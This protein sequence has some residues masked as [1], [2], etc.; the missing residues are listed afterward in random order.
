M[1]Q[2]VPLT[3][4]IAQSR[5]PQHCESLVQSAPTLRQ[6]GGRGVGVATGVGVSCGCAETTRIVA[7]RRVDIGGLLLSVQTKLT[8]NVCP[9]WFGV[10]AC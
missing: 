5:F 8:G 10:V 6:T 1:A 4:E 2:Q 7:S 9:T 3:S